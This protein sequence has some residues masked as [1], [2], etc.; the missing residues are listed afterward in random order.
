MNRGDERGAVAIIVAAF[1]TVVFALLAIIVDLGNARVMRERA[2]DAAEA[3]ALAAAIGYA[4]TGSSY[5]TAAGTAEDVAEANFGSIDW[6][7]CH[8]PG[9]LSDTA[10]SGTECI[11]F[12]PVARRVRVHLPVTPPTA[13]AGAL[14]S[15][16]PSVTGIA[17]ASWGGRLPGNCLLCVVGNATVDS[18]YGGNTVVNGG[19]L[20]VGGTV[21]VPS[22]KLIA[23]HAGNAFYG[24]SVGLAPVVDPGY[25]STSGLTGFTDPYA[26]D[27]YATDPVYAAIR[28]PWSVLPSFP[29]DYSTYR[30]GPD[31]AG[32]C[33]P[34][35]GAG[36]IG[37][38]YAPDAGSCR[39]FR[40]GIFLII[41]TG[42]GARDIQLG[43]AGSVTGSDDALLIP[44]CSAVSPAP[45][46][47][48]VPARCAGSNTNGTYLYRPGSNVTLSGVTD[49]SGPLAPF[50]GFSIIIDPGNTNP[51]QVLGVTGATRTLDITGNVYAPNQ[52][53]KVNDY[54][55]ISGQ[56]IAGDDLNIGEG[57]LP[58]AS[59]CLTLDA[60]TTVLPPLLPAAVRLIPN[61]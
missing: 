47:P 54:T 35:P 7:N 42:S 12:D 22:P 57:S 45:G 40:Q 61:G 25:Q 16:A 14:G 36:M 32:V 55:H 10:S 3:A 5:V 52:Q 1:L 60:P 15:S 18:T 17:T 37:F 39:S 38:L 58:C 11:S 26:T 34:N 24:S 33:R 44:T 50:H 49:A 41:P 9:H 51:G 29:W 4:K 20:K 19:N 13:F 21:T 23:V 56:L 43:S 31:G 27:P 30:V 28:D 46:N 6:G 53:I 59:T 8:D 48:R 2:Q